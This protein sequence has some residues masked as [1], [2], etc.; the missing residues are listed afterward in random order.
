MKLK[1]IKRVTL[2]VLLILS[3]SVTT[4]YATVTQEQIDQVKDQVGNLQQQVQDAENVLDEI[5]NQKE[6]LEDDLDDFNGQLNKLVNDMNDLEDQI[7]VKKDEIAVATTDLE[8][9]EKQVT[10]QYADMM[11]RIQ[12]MYENGSTSMLDALFGAKS[13]ADMISQTELVAELVEYDRQKLVEFQE[14]QMQIAEKKEQ[15][16]EEETSLLALQEEMGKKRIKVNSLI[17]DTEKNLEVTNQ[18]VSG[19]ESVVDNLEAQLAYWETV[20]SQLEAQKLAQDLE[21]WEEIQQS[22]GTQDWTGVGYTPADGELYLLAAI[23]QCEAEGEPYLGQLAVGS[24]VMNR[25]HSAKFPN[26]IT[27]VVYQRKQFSPVASGRLAYRLQAGVNNSCM[28]AAV[29]TLNGNI[30]TNALFFCRSE[31]KP[32]INGTIIG[33]HIFY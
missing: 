19:A 4:F 28:Q 20:E 16:E 32:N 17:A 14:L 21:K 27:E 10:K 9:A 33:H 12:Y 8:N 25:V 29:E 11:H 1:Y 31:L 22:G 2:S 23:I 6:N 15:L 3:L 13:L 5:N 26:T 24:V 18:Q 7:D 30:V